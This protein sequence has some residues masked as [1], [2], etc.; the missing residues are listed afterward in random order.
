MTFTSDRYHA[1]WLARKVERGV[2]DIEGASVSFDMV[3]E[4][5]YLQDL[6]KS[7]R[8]AQEAGTYVAPYESAGEMAQD[9]VR[10]RDR[11]DN[12][13][14]F[15]MFIRNLQQQMGIWLYI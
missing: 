8:E 12:L 10:I 14:N 13:E 11:R 2:N 15:M 9:M 4:T 7:L 1:T 5:A 6:Y 3:K